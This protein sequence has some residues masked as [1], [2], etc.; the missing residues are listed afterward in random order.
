MLQG[1]RMWQLYGDLVRRAIEASGRSPG[2]RNEQLVGR[3]AEVMRAAARGEAS[4]RR[5]SFC[6][7][8]ELDGQWLALDP[9]GTDERRIGM[10]LAMRAPRATCPAC[11]GKIR[12]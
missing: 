6:G 7:R 8:I 2:V 11:R 3:L 10:S 1:R 5:C 4:V 12:G 9:V